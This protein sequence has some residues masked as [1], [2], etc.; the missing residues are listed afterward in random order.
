MF[1][2]L[3]DRLDMPMTDFGIATAIVSVSQFC[4]VCERVVENKQDV[5]SVAASFQF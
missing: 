4:I 1:G 3:L 2:E 5:C